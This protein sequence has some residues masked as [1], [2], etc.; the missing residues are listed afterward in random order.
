MNKYQKKK[1]REIKAF[2][3]WHDRF[4]RLT[5][6]KAKRIW[7]FSKQFNAFSPC[8][9]CDNSLCREPKYAIAFCPERR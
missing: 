4:G 1:S 8:E 5:Y 2:Q 3:K 6:K 7:R 9:D